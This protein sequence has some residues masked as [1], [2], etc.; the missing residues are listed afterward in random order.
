[1][2]KCAM[3]DCMPLQLESAAGT[4]TSLADTE[5]GDSFCA[6]ADRDAGR[7]IVLSVP[8]GLTISRTLHPASALLLAHLSR[9]QMPIEVDGDVE[10][11]VNRGDDAWYVTLLNPAGQ[12]KPQQG[13]LPTDYRQNKSVTIRT[14]FAIQSISDWLAP[15]EPFSVDEGNNQQMTLTVPAGGV[16]IIQLK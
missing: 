5:T 11:L 14:R 3:F 6:F 13:I 12:G 15:D 16:R 1:M 9:Q 7:I 4:W 2:Q 10:W 8:H